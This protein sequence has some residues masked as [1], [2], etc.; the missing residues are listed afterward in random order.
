MTSR[1]SWMKSQRYWGPPTAYRGCC[2]CHGTCSACSFASCPL[3]SNE[4]S[5]LALTK[6]N[7]LIQINLWSYYQLIL[8]A[9]GWGGVGHKPCMIW[10]YENK[11]QNLPWVSSKEQNT[12]LFIL[13]PL[14]I[15]WIVQP[16]ICTDHTSLAQNILLFQVSVWH[17]CPG[18]F[19]LSP[20]SNSA[21]VYQK[22][23]KNCLCVQNNHQMGLLS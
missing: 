5:V 23:G 11:I 15:Q 16:F 13:S 12:P 8:E 19:C 14:S 3:Q 18:N 10:R 7:F 22:S 20:K 17:I 4:S 9:G 21:P 6:E 2:C 1:G